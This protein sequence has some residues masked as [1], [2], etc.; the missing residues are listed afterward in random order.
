MNKAHK[1]QTLVTTGYEIVWKLGLGLFFYKKSI[2]NEKEQ[3]IIK[4]IK[5]QHL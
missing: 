2:I 5:K 1:K 4:L 3:I